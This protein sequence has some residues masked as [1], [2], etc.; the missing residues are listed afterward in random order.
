[1]FKHNS[2]GSARWRRHKIIILIIPSADSEESPFPSPSEELKDREIKQGRRQ[3]H[4]AKKGL[5][6]S[7]VFNFHDCEGAIGNMGVTKGSRV[8]R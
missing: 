6:K 3:R 2:E 1:L 7:E 5:W 4:S 8:Y